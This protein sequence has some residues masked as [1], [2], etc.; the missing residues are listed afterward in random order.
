[1]PSDSDSEAAEEETIGR[2]EFVSQLKD[3][4]LKTVTSSLSAV[5]KGVE[6]TQVG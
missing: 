6:E 4:K 2:E 3:E 5:Q 1:M